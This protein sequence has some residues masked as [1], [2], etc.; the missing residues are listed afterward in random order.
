[1]NFVSVLFFLLGLG[2]AAYGAYIGYLRFRHDAFVRS[3]RAECA[4]GT[5]VN[6]RWTSGGL[7]ASGIRYVDTKGCQRTTWTR[8][9]ASIPVPVGGTARVV[10]DPQGK[11]TALVNGVATGIGSH[12]FATGCFVLSAV[13]FFNAVLRM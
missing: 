5:C 3:G 2:L 13:F 6:L 8:A 12:G 11:A 1:M 7:V 10:Y 4:K 9:Q